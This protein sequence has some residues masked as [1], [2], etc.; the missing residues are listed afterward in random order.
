MPEIYEALR[1]EIDQ[2]RELEN[3]AAQ[4]K[5]YRDFDQ[6]R[7]KQNLQSRVAPMRDPQS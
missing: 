4:F 6:E 2:N 1:D 5:Y 7:Y 3:Y